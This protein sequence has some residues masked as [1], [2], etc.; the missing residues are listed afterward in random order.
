VSKIEKQF[1]LYPITNEKEDNESSKHP[2][3]H[4][5]SLQRK[6]LD[7]TQLTTIIDELNC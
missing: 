5:I 1:L 7:N 6:D 2:K 4:R 3:I